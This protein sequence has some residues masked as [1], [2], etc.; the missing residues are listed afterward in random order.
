MWVRKTNQ[1]SIYKVQ[2]FRP[3][4]YTDKYCP[5]RWYRASQ[6]T[7]NLIITSTNFVTIK[8]NAQSTH[9]ELFV[10]IY[11]G[12]KVNPKGKIMHLWDVRTKISLLTVAY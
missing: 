11:F 8:N 4:R 3:R 6:Q 10:K 1:Q 5:S 12:D 7:P 9:L 2:L